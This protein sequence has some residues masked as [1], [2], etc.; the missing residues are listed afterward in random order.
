MVAQIGESLGV[1]SGDHNNESGTPLQLENA[2]TASYN[3]TYAK[4][5]KDQTSSLVCIYIQQHK[6]P[7]NAIIDSDGK[8]Y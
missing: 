4:N 1:S 5:F 3:H 7:L 6:V 2:V 8:V